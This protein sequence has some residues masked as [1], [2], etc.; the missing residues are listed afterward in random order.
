MA[1]AFGQTSCFP[2]SWETK[3]MKEERHGSCHSSQTPTRTYTLNV[4][5][6]FNETMLGVKI[7]T[8]GPCRWFVEHNRRWK[9]YV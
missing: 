5:S 3:P 4:H 1:T 8:P 9:L 7:F 6:S 2:C